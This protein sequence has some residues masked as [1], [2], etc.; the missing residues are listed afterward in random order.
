MQ[1]DVSFV[2]AAYN[3]ERSVARA[4]ES[5]RAQQGVTLEVVVVDDCSNDRTVEVVRSFPPDQV[6]LVELEENRGPGGARNA[7]LEAARGRWIAVLDSDDAVYS[8]RLARMI[9]YAERQ[10]AQI[11]VDNLDVVQEASGVKTTM[12]APALLEK[13]SELC[14]ADFIAANLLFED[15]FSFGYMKPIFERSF[16]ERNALRYDEILRIGEDYI[17]LASALARGGRCAVDPQ[18][19]YAYYIRS[20]SISR[21]LE[22]HHVEAMLA[23]DA[24]FLREHQL[25]AGAQSA[26][27]RR[28]RS[29]EEAASFLTLVNHLKQR[30]PLRA[31]RT[32]LRDPRAVRHLKMPIAARLRRLGLPFFPGRAVGEV[33]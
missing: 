14:L 30:A 24:A 4:I 26:Q 29:L 1:P 17:F 31:I 19:G 23:A 16:L 22:L 12:F 9:S 2:I 10:D 5:A 18:P 21:V 13:Y 7:G 28:T 15:T 8:D 20:G 6:R 25:D 3:A 32:A 33:G 11:A 27:A